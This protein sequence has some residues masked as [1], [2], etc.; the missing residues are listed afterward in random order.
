MR[1]N[2]FNNPKEREC[3]MTTE[4]KTL[5]DKLLADQKAARLEK[6]NKDPVK[7]SLL[8]TLYSEAVNV[9]KNKGNRAST[10]EEVMSIIKKFVKGTNENIEIYEKTSKAEALETAR[11]EL[12]IL[13]T[14]LPQAVTPEALEE[15]VANFVK[16]KQLKKE[17][18][19]T[20]GAVMKASKEHFGASLD[21]AVAS[22]TIKEFLAKPDAV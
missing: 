5:L 15:Y 14:Y 11:K 20:F 3:I 9:G 18:K 6:V 12:A 8:T 4:V 2:K 7:I 17:D 19:Q 21:G 1:F 16:D 22:K 13:Q 10:D